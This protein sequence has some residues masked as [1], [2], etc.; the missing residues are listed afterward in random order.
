VHSKGSSS[1]EHLSKLSSNHS[2]STILSH[3]FSSQANYKHTQFTE[4][5]KQKRLLPTEDATTMHM[6]ALTLLSLLAI[7]RTFEH[8]TLREI[9]LQS[10]VMHKMLE[11]KQT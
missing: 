1:S 2:M 11:Q 3:A 10:M 9:E 4:S 8:W 6:K 5:L 7:K